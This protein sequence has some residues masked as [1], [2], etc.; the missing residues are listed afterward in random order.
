MGGVKAPGRAC[1]R[2]SRVYWRPRRSHSVVRGPG[3]H[4]GGFLLQSL[5]SAAVA[6]ELRS[7]TAHGIFLGQQQ[8]LRLLPWQVGS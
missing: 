3:S 4:C 2:F 7:S 8:S 5:G 1:V 6:R